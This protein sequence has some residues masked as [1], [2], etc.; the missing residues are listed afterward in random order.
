MQLFQT[1]F[2]LN[3][4]L[5]HVIVDPIQYCSL[6]KQNIFRCLQIIT[7]CFKLPSKNLSR[8]NLKRITSTS[9]TF[10][11]STKITSENQWF[12]PLKTFSANKYKLEVNNINTRKPWNMLGVNNKD[13]R[14]TSMTLL[15][16]LNQFCIVLV[17]PLLTLNN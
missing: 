14:T 4:C 9:Y 16:I 6:R 1:F 5:F 15:I 3:W 11:K 10:P 7:A 12:K 17:L 2:H 13:T 8:V